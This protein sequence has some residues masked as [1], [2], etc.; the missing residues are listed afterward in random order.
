MSVRAW[1]LEVSS[2][3][4]EMAMYL[5]FGSNELEVVASELNVL[6]LD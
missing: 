5:H 6:E 3:V 4:K 2:V 1:L